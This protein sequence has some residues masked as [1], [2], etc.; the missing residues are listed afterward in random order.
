MKTE[1]YSWRVAAGLK[2]GLEREARR[3]KMSLS[4]VLD[5]ATQE[6]LMKSSAEN[7]DDEEQRQLQ[8]AALKCFG[9]L[10]SGN[11]RRSETVKQ[12]V[13]TRLRR[14]YGR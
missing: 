11:R 8:R 1:V 6:W 12:E 13:R 5:L 7:N 9:I 10:A 2:A 3:R 4:A 14:R